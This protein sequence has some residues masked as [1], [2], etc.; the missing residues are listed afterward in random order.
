MHTRYDKIN[1][2]ATDCQYCTCKKA[3]FFPSFPIICLSRCTVKTATDM[4]NRGPGI[5]NSRR[6]TN[7]HWSKFIDTH[8]WTAT[9]TTRTSQNHDVRSHC[10]HAVQKLPKLCS[11][12]GIVD[13]GLQ[14]PELPKYCAAVFL[15]RFP[16]QHHFKVGS[17]TASQ[18]GPRLPLLVYL[19]LAFVVQNLHIHLLEGFRQLLEEA[20]AYGWSPIFLQPKKA[21]RQDW[22]TGGMLAGFRPIIS[23]SKCFPNFST[24]WKNM[25]IL[26][27]FEQD[28]FQ[29]RGVCS[30]GPE[31]C[32]IF[33][34][35]MRH[36]RPGLA[37]PTKIEEWTTW[38]KHVTKKNVGVQCCKLNENV[39]LTAEGACMKL[40]PIDQCR[41]KN[42]LQKGIRG[43]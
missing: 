19:D 29:D 35:E 7:A 25:E 8:W 15:G 13:P 10:I 24:C 43:T 41:F 23:H 32:S 38:T 39:T 34:R 4:Y 18:Q 33:L 14:I 31:S 3:K 2:S 6:D 40:N 22:N 16:L 9:L 17:H 20:P 11:S 5:T 21:K 37:S 27:N 1:S 12:S 30:K 42:M 28:P 36:L 26:R